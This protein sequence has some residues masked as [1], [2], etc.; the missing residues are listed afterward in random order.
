MREHLQ[1]IYG[2]TNLHRLEVPVVVRVDPV[3]QA[4][5]AG[6]DHEAE[7]VK[8]EEVLGQTLPEALR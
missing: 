5:R 7:R 1:T 4:E 3:A 6:V 2:S 8:R